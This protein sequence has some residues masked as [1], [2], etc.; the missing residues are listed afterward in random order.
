MRTYDDACRPVPR[1]DS[2][3]RLPIVGDHNSVRP[4]KDLDAVPEETTSIDNNA[5][6]RFEANVYQD[7]P[8]SLS[9]HK[10]MAGQLNVPGGG[11]VEK[12]VVLDL[13]YEL[14]V[15]VEDIRLNRR[16]PSPRTNASKGVPSTDTGRS[17]VPY[18]ASFV[19]KLLPPITISHSFPE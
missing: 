12:L 13:Q 18:P 1:A 8:L 3:K 19:L 17:L 11:G 4:D 5:T 16:C 10:V 9:N 6:R 2:G 14:V 15:R 7:P